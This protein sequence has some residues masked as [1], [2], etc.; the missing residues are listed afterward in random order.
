MPRLLPLIR[1]C[2][3]LPWLPAVVRAAPIPLQALPTLPVGKYEPLSDRWQAFLKTSSEE[4][5]G[6]YS[7]QTGAK[8]GWQSSTRRMV[9]SENA[10]FLQAREVANYAYKLEGQMV[11]HQVAVEYRFETKFPH[12]LTWA[13]HEESRGKSRRTVSLTRTGKGEYDVEILDGGVGR[14]RELSNLEFTALDLLGGRLWALEP[15]RQRGDCKSFRGLDVKTLEPFV[16]KVCV[17][18]PLNQN[19]AQAEVTD[20]KHEFASLLS[21]TGNGE[22]SGLVI[23]GRSE[24]R[25]ESP[26]QARSVSDAADLLEESYVP[27][28]RPLGKDVRKL[29]PLRL[30]LHGSGLGNLPET[31]FQQAD[32]QPATSSI[33]L[34]TG[35]G[36]AKPATEKEIADNLKSTALLPLEQPAIKALARK[37]IGDAVTPEAKVKRL[38][39]FVSQFI[40]DD[41]QPSPLGV[42]EILQHPRGDCTT[43][44]LLFTVLARA[45]GIPCR[46]AT[47][48]IYLGDQKQAFGGH[49][50]N[51][52]VLGGQ[53]H[54]VDPTWE[55][56]TLNPAHIQLGSGTPGLRD[57]RFFNGGVTVEVR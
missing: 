3:L 50:W 49:A 46:E 22:L 39:K 31:K 36:I 7:V 29:G 42:M 37:A 1:F 23:A 33:S 38:L 56:F 54:P 43:H 44:S 45:S 19:V 12:A 53:W 47:G 28:S 10:A 21:L 8:L 26:D 4:T 9:N 52:V 25:S 24:L 27:C 35:G 57:A 30:V 32:S 2:C 48:L 51:E 11:R 41:D 34:T 15:G 5:F 18:Q 14:R 13:S 20:L 55:E 16:Q 6:I 40:K 17:T